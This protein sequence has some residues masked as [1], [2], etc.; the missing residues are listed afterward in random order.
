MICVYL[1]CALLLCQLKWMQ[2]W[3][4]WVTLPTLPRGSK[5]SPDIPYV[6]IKLNRDYD[7]YCM[8]VLVNCIFCE[9]CENFHPLLHPFNAIALKGCERSHCWDGK[10]ALSQRLWDKAQ[11]AS[12]LELVCEPAV[13]PLGRYQCGCIYE[14][15]EADNWLLFV[16]NVYSEYMNW[17]SNVCFQAF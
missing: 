17:Y 12:L 4:M 3:K 6:I 11:R 13:R 15:W 1:T 10:R 8:K 14:R 5:Y 16:A 2:L 9:I 7:Y